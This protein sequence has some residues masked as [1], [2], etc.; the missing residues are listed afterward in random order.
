MDRD[1]DELPQ[2]EGAHIT[3][4]ALFVGG[5][6]DGVIAMNPTGIETMKTLC[7]DCAGSTL[8]PGAGHWTQQERP[9]ETNAALIE[10]LKGL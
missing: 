6:K 3:Q 1:W 2:L 7:D 10:F 9:A 8:L 4:P 5:E